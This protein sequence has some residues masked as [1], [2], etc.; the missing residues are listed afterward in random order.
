MGDGGELVVVGFGLRNLALVIFTCFD[1][2][3]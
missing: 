3:R 2:I 1:R